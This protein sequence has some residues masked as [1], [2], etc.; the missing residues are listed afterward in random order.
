MFG[1]LFPEYSHSYYFILVTSSARRVG[2]TDTGAQKNNF[3][4][5]GPEFN[6][7]QASQQNKTPN[8]CVFL[9]NF[10]NLGDHEYNLNR[11]C[12]LKKQKQKEKRKKKAQLLLV[13]MR[14]LT[15]NLSFSVDLSHLLACG[16]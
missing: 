16:P 5:Y 9:P 11:S 2:R 12:G 14:F 7:Q 13:N 4:T 15:I 6:S 8:F 10:F 1:K 3:T